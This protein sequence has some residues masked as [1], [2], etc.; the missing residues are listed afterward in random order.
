[1]PDDLHLIGFSLDDQAEPL[2]L[3]IEIGPICAAAQQFRSLVFQKF[4][5]AGFFPQIKNPASTVYLASAPFFQTQENVSRSAADR[6]LDSPEGGLEASW[7]QVGKG[8]YQKDG[9]NVENRK[10]EH[11]QVADD[12]LASAVSPGKPGQLLG[13]FEPADFEAFLH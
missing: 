6:F 8:A 9:P 12:H 1:M 3:R 11:F 10:I 7:R 5:N 2:V 4:P 13:A